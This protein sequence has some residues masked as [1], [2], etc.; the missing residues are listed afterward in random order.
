MLAAAPP[1]ERARGTSD[2]DAAR[3]PWP[4]CWPI[5][6]P[7]EPPYHRPPSAGG[8]GAADPAACR[9]PTAHA[10]PGSSSAACRRRFGLRIAR[11]SK[12][13]PHLPFPAPP[14][15]QARLKPPAAYIAASLFYAAATLTSRAHTL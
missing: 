10:S 8:H 4:A 6:P 12:R 3:L 15:M 9:L 11:R 2:T 13:S 7:R 14:A 1:A 5:H